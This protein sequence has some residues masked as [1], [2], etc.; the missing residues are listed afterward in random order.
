MLG[1][2]TSQ[3]SDYTGELMHASVIRADGWMDEVQT[4]YL[5]DL[6]C[7]MVYHQLQETKV[8]LLKETL[9]EKKQRWFRKQYYWMNDEGLILHCM[10]D[11]LCIPRELQTKVLPEAYD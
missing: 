1:E 9:G 10:T 7:G 2:P 8:C 6:Y 3:S 5:G 4:V 11:R